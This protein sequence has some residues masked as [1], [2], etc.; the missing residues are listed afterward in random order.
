MNTKQKVLREGRTR[1]RQAALSCKHRWF[2]EMN[3]WK[4]GSC[5]CLPEFR[6]THYLLCGTHKKQTEKQVLT[7]GSCETSAYNHIYS[8]TTCFYSVFTQYA[9]SNHYTF[10]RLNKRPLISSSYYPEF[11]SGHLRFMW[12]QTFYPRCCNYISTTLQ[13]LMISNRNYHWL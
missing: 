4:W 1:R 2:K 13:F 10:Q 9:C 5:C 7:R 11:N 8:D 3:L 6:R 12:E